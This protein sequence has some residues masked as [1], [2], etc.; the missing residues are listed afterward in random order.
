MALIISATINIPI[1]FYLLDYKPDVQRYSNLN[2]SS[3]TPYYENIKEFPDK[4]LR[5]FKMQKLKNWQDLAQE[6]DPSTAG[7]FSLT[8]WK[9]SSD[10]KSLLAN[11]RINNTRA[12]L[13]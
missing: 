1:K 10:F 9:L 8:F 6:T 3:V 13:S 11:K 7:I 5:L 2:L 4:N 12:Q